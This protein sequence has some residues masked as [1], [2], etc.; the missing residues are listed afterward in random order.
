MGE[1]RDMNA[2]FEKGL[3][4]LNQAEFDEARECFEGVVLEDAAHSEAWFR[5]G[6][7]YLE[8]GRPDLAI[9][10]LSRTLKLNPNNADAHYLLG[11]AYGSS[12]LLEK[13][14]EKYQNALAVQPHHPKSEEFIV[15]TQ[16]LIQSREHYRKAARLFDDGKLR[17]PAHD[18]FQ[19][20]NEAFRALI[21]SVALFSQSPAGHEFE[22]CI[23]V[24]LDRGLEQ[25][26]EAGITDE[27]QFWVEHCE[28]GRMFLTSRLW[29]GA[30]QGF[31]EAI[32]FDPHHAF[33]HHGMGI[34]QYQMGDL[35]GAMKSWLAALE[36]GPG[37]DF[38]RIGRLRIPK[39]FLPKTQ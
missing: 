15:R 30:Y 9:E 26:I 35:Q 11:N 17:D 24:I 14:L 23:K 32:Q 25:W 39:Q 8:T 5:L 37:F 38:A 28:R 21:E 10:A 6:V 34:A 3:Y 4:E 2:L 36:I 20:L 12:G 13:A 18:D 29:P 1:I 27:N 31:S 16:A 19:W 22:A 7:C 33:I